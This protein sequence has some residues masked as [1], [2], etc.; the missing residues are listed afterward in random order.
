[1]G[2]WLDLKG[3]Q[4]FYS[5]GRSNKPTKAPYENW[6]VGIKSK[7][8]ITVTTKTKEGKEPEKSKRRESQESTGRRASFF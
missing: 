7:S 6:L 3:L 1:V 4:Q 2:L 5:S 8:N